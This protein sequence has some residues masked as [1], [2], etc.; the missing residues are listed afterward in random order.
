MNNSSLLAKESW[1]K[2]LSIIIRDY[3]HF[4]LIAG[5]GNQDDRVINEP[6]PTTAL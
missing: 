5:N 3:F 2:V 6:K 4:A 1:N